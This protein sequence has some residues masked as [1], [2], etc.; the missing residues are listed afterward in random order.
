MVKIT[1]LPNAGPL[2]GT[3]PVVIVQG[4]QT[5]QGPIGALV[6]QLAQPFVDRAEAAAES[7]QPLPLNTRIS[8]FISRRK[9]VAGEI[10]GPFLAT[11]GAPSAQPS[12][13]IT[14]GALVI[15]GS[16]TGNTEV[17]RYWDTGLRWS[18]V[19]QIDVTTKATTALS[20]Q[21]PG[22]TIGIGTPAGG[23]VFF[24]YRRTG[25]CNIWLADGTL[26]ASSSI[27][28]LAMSSGQEG[29]LRVTV[30][31]DGTGVM[32]MTGPSGNTIS[33]TFGAGSGYDLDATAAVTILADTGEKMIVPGTVGSSASW[34]MIEL[35]MIE[36]SSTTIDRLQST[37]SLLGLDGGAAPV[38]LDWGVMGDVEVGRYPKGCTCTGLSKLTA[39]PFKDCW[40]VGDGGGLVEEASPRVYEPQ[41]HIYSELSQ[42]PILSIAAG[43]TGNSLQGVVAL[44]DGTI[45]AACAGNNTVRHY[46]IVQRATSPFD[47]YG[48]EIVADRI[49]YADID[50]SAY[51]AAGAPNGICVIDGNL[52]VADDTGVF[53]EFNPNPAVSPRLVQTKSFTGLSI[54]QLHA[55]GSVIMLTRGNNGTPGIVGRIRWATNVYTTSVF[56]NLVP[57]EAIEGIHIDTSDAASTATGVMTIVSDGGFHDAEPRLN[58]WARY[59]IP[60]NA[61]ATQ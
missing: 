7:V 50:G 30:N 61:W 26:V 8:S 36:L 51:T 9:F 2:T 33:R 22:A 17:F 58:L 39:G 60:T 13:V 27:D 59:R 37:E 19:G 10:S 42:M 6:E 25:S 44:A 1:T 12:G 32:F 49:D 29:S 11:T 24:R 57:C 28:A 20:T 43:Y 41:I 46:R 48:E 15:S 52:I 35:S 56:R 5:R 34:S 18:N 40:V 31:P 38:L 55:V 16:I 3:E 4:G 47:F 45:W 23:F 53:T 21:S 14:S 54:D